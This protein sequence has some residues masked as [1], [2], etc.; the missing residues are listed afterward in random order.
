MAGSS[1]LTVYAADCRTVL[2]DAGEKASS[3]TVC[4]VVPEYCITRQTASVENGGKRL[5]SSDSDSDPIRMNA[6]KYTG[7]R[8]SR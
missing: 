7:S 5:D 1:F 2:K 6:I 8:E 4:S 3:T